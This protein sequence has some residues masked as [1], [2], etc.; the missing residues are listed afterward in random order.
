MPEDVITSATRLVLANAIYFNGG[1][2]DPFDADSTEDGDFHLLDGSTVTAPFMVQ[3]VYLR[4]AVG[5]GFTLVEF[6][7]AGSGLSFLVI[8]PDEGKFDTVQ[9]EPRSRHAERGDRQAQ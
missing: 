2:A 6:R 4:Y 1:W 9:Q 7:Y 8:L 5:D 3:G